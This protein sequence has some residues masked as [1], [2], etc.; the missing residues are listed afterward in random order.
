M[1]YTDM[2]IDAIQNAKKSWLNAV[3]QNDE[4][5][6]PLTA[7]VDAQTSFTKQIWKTGTDVSTTISK[8]AFNMMGGK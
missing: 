5:K 7:F 2:A 6:T 3:V 8:N 1:F 4:M